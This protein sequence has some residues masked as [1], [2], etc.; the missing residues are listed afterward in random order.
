VQNHLRKCFDNIERII[1]TDESES[2]DIIGMISG[3]KENVMFSEKVQAVG[4]VEYWLT[5]IEEMMRKSLYDLSKKALNLY[6]SNGLD[7]RQWFFDHNLP[8]Q[9]VLLID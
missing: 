1:F 7:R 6:P 9:S 2:V 5:N 4:N 8:A 3:E